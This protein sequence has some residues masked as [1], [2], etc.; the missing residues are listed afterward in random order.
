MI[1][2]WAGSSGHKRDIEAVSDAIAQVMRACSQVDFAFMGDEEI[3]RSLSAVLPSGRI[4]YTPPGTLEE[5][6]VFLQKLDIGIAPLQ[7]N[8][9]NRCRSDVKFLEYASR[10]VVP[11]LSSLTPYKASAQQ[12]ETAFFYESPWQ[13]VEILTRSC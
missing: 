6:L 3:Y 2:G 10:G 12:G 5:Y 7:D 4:T 8:P 9:Y 1:V 11:V 13:L